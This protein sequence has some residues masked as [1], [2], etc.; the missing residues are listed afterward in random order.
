MK[1]VQISA[2]DST[3]NGLLRELNT[4]ILN[5]GHTLICVCSDGNK[6][7]KMK[8]EGFDIRTINID[9]KISPIKNVKS[10]INMVKLFRKEKPDV[11][12]VHT[13]VASVLGRI[14]AKL[15]KVPTIIYTAHGFYFHENMTPMKY[16]IFYLIEKWCAKLCTNYIFTQ[17]EEDGNLAIENNFL[18]NDRIT[19]I[20]N[21]VDVNKSFN[22]TN[23]NENRIR[24][25]KEEFSFRE[26][27]VIVTFIG[28]LVKEKGILDLLEAFNIIEKENIKLLVIGETSATE[29]DQ[30]TK[31]QLE[32]HRSNPNIIFTG[33][34][35]DIPDLLALTDI[36]CLP[37]YR[38][39]MPR[40][41]IE[42]M[43]M[44]CAIIATNIRGSREEVDNS[45]NG[46]LVNLKSPDEIASSIINLSTSN[47]TLNS[48]KVKAREKAV[49]YYDEKKVVKRQLDVFNKTT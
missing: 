2:I 3:M 40:S 8:D 26:N 1:I 36:Y 43:A 22:P 14:A 9:R 24:E 19:V 41:I 27:D 34:R 18:P 37:S 42:A 47:K 48:F 20:S 6:V 25:L 5:E 33:Y 46:Y 12:H 29:R 44:E 11:V 32:I 45:L 13:P 15:A 38:E 31:V 21:G 7:K 17:S 39:G 10:I 16:K 28:R 23:I 4:T 30:E 35:N 49:K